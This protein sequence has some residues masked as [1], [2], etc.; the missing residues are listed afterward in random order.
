[1]LGEG[2][3]EKWQQNMLAQFEQHNRRGENAYTF[4]G[5]CF[6]DRTASNTSTSFSE[7]LDK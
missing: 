1:M 6:G 2:G 3:R 5:L 4:V 7:S